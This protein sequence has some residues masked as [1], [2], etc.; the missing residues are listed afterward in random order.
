METTKKERFNVI[1]ES[2]DIYYYRLTQDQINLLAKLQECAL[3]DVDYYVLDKDVTF[4][5][6]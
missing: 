2:D 4:E 1:V 6:I 5:E 3:I